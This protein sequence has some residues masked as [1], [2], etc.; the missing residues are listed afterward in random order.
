[1]A[2]LLNCSAREALLASLIRVWIPAVP[3]NRKGRTQDSYDIL[4]LVTLV[5]LL[6]ELLN[7]CWLVLKLA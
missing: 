4:I 2:K 5:K 6:P 1:M 3:F 7:Y